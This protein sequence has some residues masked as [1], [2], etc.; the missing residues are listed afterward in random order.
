[1]STPTSKKQE[2]EEEEGGLLVCVFFKATV[3]RKA[4]TH[5]LRVLPFWQPSNASL[6]FAVVE[7]HS[8]LQKTCFL[9]VI[10]KDFNLLRETV[11]S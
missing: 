8:S 11:K 4:S 6:K 3:F 5:L 2:E 10:S 7:I 9:Y 1:M